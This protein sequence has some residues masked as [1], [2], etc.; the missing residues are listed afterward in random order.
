MV[1]ALICFFFFVV[2]LIY[3]GFN[4]F[5]FFFRDVL[6]VNVRGLR[7]QPSSHDVGLTCLSN[8]KPLDL[9]DFQVQSAY[10]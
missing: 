8:P 10:T 6:I 9:A 4:C 5:M 3:S 2:Y 1:T 7:S